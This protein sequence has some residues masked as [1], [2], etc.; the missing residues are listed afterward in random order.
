MNRAQSDVNR[1]QSN[2]PAELDAMLAKGEG[3]RLEFKKSLP[4]RRRLARLLAGLANSGGAT[5]LVGV[6]D[7][8]HVVGVP[9]P[10]EARSL[11]E[12]VAREELDP[13]PELAFEVINAGDKRVLAIRVAAPPA[14]EPGLTAPVA[15]VYEKACSL[16]ARVNDHLQPLTRLPDQAQAPRSERI[17]SLPLATRARYLTVLAAAEHTGQD[18]LRV[19]QYARRCNVSLRTARRDI[20]ALCQAFLLVPVG[21]GLYE[22]VRD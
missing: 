18:R 10:C 22:L 1:A 11:V 9:N 21:G 16:V 4:A 17:A 7:T 15:L 14:I 2:V 6:D 8:R 5:I 19:A 3:Q 20:V 12:Q 13:Q